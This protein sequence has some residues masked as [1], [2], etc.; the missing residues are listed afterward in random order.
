[1]SVVTLS[2]VRRAYDGAWALDNVSLTAPE[3]KVLALLG[4]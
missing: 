3:A 2:H 1:M 4:P